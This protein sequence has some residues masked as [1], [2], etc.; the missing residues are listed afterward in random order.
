MTDSEML[1]L[2]LLLMACTIAEGLEEEMD[3]PLWSLSNGWTMSQSVS[4]SLHLLLSSPRCSVNSTRVQ[5]V[6]YELFASASK[7]WQSPILPSASSLFFST[8]LC[9]DLHFLSLHKKLTLWLLVTSSRLL[10]SLALD[11][12]SVCRE[13]AKPQVGLRPLKWT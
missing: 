4:P 1:L 7:A 13:L 8:G 5:R 9:A 10:H 3:K 2:L 12:R 6:T 11:S